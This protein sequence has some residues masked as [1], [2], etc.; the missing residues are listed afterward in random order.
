MSV[1]LP[2]PTVAKSVHV[3]SG[4]ERVA[5]LDGIAPTDISRGIMMRCGEVQM[6]VQCVAALFRI[7]H[8]AQATL[9]A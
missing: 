4:F 5:L 8:V 3:P 1:V 7:R 2:R 6:G 9:V